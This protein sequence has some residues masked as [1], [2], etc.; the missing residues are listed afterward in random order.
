[1]IMLPYQRLAQRCAR[2]GA[3]RCTA[4]P[5]PTAGTASMQAAFRRSRVGSPRLPTEPRQVQVSCNGSMDGDLCQ[6]TRGR[7]PLGAVACHL[8]PAV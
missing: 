8:A 1:M 7:G 3:R 4:C 2:H 5:L 6:P